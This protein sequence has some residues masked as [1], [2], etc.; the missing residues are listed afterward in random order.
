ML[1]QSGERGKGEQ[2]EKTWDWDGGVG[3]NGYIGKLLACVKYW[4]SFNFNAYKI[5]THI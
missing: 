3:E 4:L 2:I 1:E 5:S